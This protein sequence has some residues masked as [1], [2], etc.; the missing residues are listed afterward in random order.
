MPNRLMSRVRPGVLLE[1]AR[2][3]WLVSTLIAE[4]L[5]ALERPTKQTSGPV[6]AGSWSRRAAETVKR[7]RCRMDTGNPVTVNF[8]CYCIIAGLKTHES[9]S[10]IALWGCLATSLTE[11]AAPP[12]PGRIRDRR[13]LHE[14]YAFQNGCCQRRAA[15]HL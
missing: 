7:A 15:R 11:I 12:V 9:G 8:N 2:R 13:G 5:P 14:A 4:D 6:G 1:N 10:P 3:R